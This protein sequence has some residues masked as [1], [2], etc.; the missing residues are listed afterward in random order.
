MTTVVT[1][2]VQSA[3]N[4]AYVRSLLRQRPGLGRKLVM[5]LTRSAERP[6]ACGSGGDL[7]LRVDI[8]P[9][10]PA[11][12]EVSGELDIASASWLRETL[13]LAIRR[14]GPAICVD[15]QGV[16]FLD[17]SGI[18]ALLATA[19]RARLEGG[20]MRV[21]SPSAPARRVIGLLGL[22]NVL[23]SADERAENATMPGQAG[24]GDLMS[25]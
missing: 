15:L 14:H 9:G 5:P 24:E 19:R 21:L 23:T 20:G 17:C 6:P 3:E 1:P 11:V 16:T 2:W 18:N 12:A 25:F 13:L 22:Q 7:G 10:V 4:M 8:L